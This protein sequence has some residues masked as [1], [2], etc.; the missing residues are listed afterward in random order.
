MHS[1]AGGIGFVLP[2]QPVA[3]NCCW[4]NGLDLTAVWAVQRHSPFASRLPCD[5]VGSDCAACVSWLVIQA[6][7]VTCIGRPC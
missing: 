5:M 3:A 6:G 2:K 4:L 7:P 1:A